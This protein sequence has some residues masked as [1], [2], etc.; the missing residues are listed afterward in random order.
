MLSWVSM[1]LSLFIPIAARVEMNRGLLMFLFLLAASILSRAIGLIS[2]S[3][4]AAWLGSTQRKMMS[5]SLTIL[6]LLNSEMTIEFV[7]STMF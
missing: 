6:S 3:I 7:L 4:S 2:L 1:S 5:H